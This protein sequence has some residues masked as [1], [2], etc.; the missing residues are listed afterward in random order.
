M[1]TEYK[2][3]Y[4]PGRRVSFPI[5]SVFR[6]CTSTS[7]PTVIKSLDAR[8]KGEPLPPKHPSPQARKRERLGGIF[9]RDVRDWRA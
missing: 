6:T 4:R 1:K 2:S 8:H 7:N 3:G 9:A 5:I